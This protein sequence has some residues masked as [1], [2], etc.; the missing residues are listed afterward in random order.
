MCSDEFTGV[1][2]ISDK[3]FENY[4]Q[5]NGGQEDGVFGIAPPPPTKVYCRSDILS[6]LV[7]SAEVFVKS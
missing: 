2:Q 4:A 5:L 6:S 7:L 3:M 1:L